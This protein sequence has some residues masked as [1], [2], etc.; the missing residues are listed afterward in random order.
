MPIYTA[1]TESVQ[2]SSLFMLSHLDAEN[3]NEKEINFLVDG[4][5]DLPPV[6]YDS[7]DW[8]DPQ[9][10]L[11]KPWTLLD[12]IEQG[13]KKGNKFHCGHRVD[14]QITLVHGAQ[15]VLRETISEKLRK[16][17]QLLSVEHLTSCCMLGLVV[18]LVG[19]V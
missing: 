3:R 14:K 18:D 1:K 10:E 15:V 13:T 7:Y 16:G 17:V 6:Q 5:K 19:R 4:D 11:E 8:F 12:N 2:R 9:A